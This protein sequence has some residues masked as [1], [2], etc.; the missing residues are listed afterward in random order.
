MPKTKAG[1]WSVGLIIAF[2]LLFATSQLL[3][4]A[5]GQRGPVLDLVFVVAVITAGISGVAA[6]FTGLISIIKSK[7][8][9][10]L[11]FIATAIGLFV[12]IFVLGEF[13]VTH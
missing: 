3:P 4:A 6:F 1:K 5:F 11:V 13:L 12:L 8:R 9:S 10:F 2:L 7:E